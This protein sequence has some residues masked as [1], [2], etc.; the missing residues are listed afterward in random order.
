MLR[1]FPLFALLT[2]VFPHLALAAPSLE[3]Q[4]L[5]CTERES[6]FH[7]LECFDKVATALKLGGFDRAV[8]STPPSAPPTPEPLSDLRFEISAK[9][10]IARK[11]KSARPMLRFE[12]RSRQIAVAIIPGLTLPPQEPS[13][14]TRVDSA[15]IVTE[16]WSK[17]GALSPPS[18]AKLLKRLQGGLT[19][20]VK[21][22]SGKAEPLRFSFDLTGVDRRLAALTR[23]CLS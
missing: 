19:L 18:P 8:K 10:D 11:G 5:A 15:D 9:R 7:R 12:C 14:S 23:A 22:V 2:L 17:G 6:G 3:E 13:V 1:I 16:S 4:V 21:V 20:E